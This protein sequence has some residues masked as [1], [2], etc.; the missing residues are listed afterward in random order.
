MGYKYINVEYMN[1]ILGDDVETN[2]EIIDLF[3]EQEREIY[4]E[5]LQLYQNADYHALGLLAH[6]AKGAVSILGME[7]LSVMLKTFELTAV[8]S[9]GVDNYPA[10]IER[11]KDETEEAIVELDDYLTT[12]KSKND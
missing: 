1:S 5:M 3:K 7:D 2:K 12:L 10:Y 4:E 11:F 6:K 9:E 8:K